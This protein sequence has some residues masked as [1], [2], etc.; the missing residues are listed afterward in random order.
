[1]LKSTGLGNFR[2][3]DVEDLTNALQ[4][5]IDAPLIASRLA[6]NARKEAH[7]RFSHT[8]AC[9]RLESLLDRMNPVR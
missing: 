4:R 3:V 1:M 5:L 9:E 2:T 6:E 7:S 8:N